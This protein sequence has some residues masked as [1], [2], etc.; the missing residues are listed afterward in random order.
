M[1][2]M[3]VST[4]KVSA[5]VNGLLFLLIHCSLYLTLQCVK[6][7]D[8]KYCLHQINACLYIIINLFEVVSY[9]NGYFVRTAG[10]LPERLIV[11]STM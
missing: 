2:L 5:V 8:C 6:F 4:A 7:K 3:S 10:P 11:L 9:F 1:L